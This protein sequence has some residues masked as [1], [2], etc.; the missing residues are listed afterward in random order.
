MRR[1]ILNAVSTFW[2]CSRPR[3][4]SRSTG[5][6]DSVPGPSLRQ[7]LCNTIHEVPGGVPGTRRSHRPSLFL[8]YSLDRLNCP[9]S[10]PSEPFARI[11]SPWRFVSLPTL[12]VV[13]Q[14]VSNNNTLMGSLMVAVRCDACLTRTMMIP[15]W[16]P[17]GTPSPLKR[18]Y[19]VYISPSS[20]Y[21]APSAKDVGCRLRVATGDTKGGWVRPH[22]SQLSHYPL[23][24]PPQMR[25]FLS[26]IPV[27]FLGLSVSA[28]A[29]NTTCKNPKVRREWRKLS[30]TE[31][32][33]WINAVNV[34]IPMPQ[35]AHNADRQLLVPCHA[36]P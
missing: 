11:P 15:P 26:I 18:E 24:S 4:V 3:A 7:G 27:L 28:A 6:Q 30:S 14:S 25:P 34:F 32:S 33:E 10:T 31:R 20:F 22:S 12:G 36:S 29:T 13:V 16:I 17:L 5:T 2:D 1:I 8:F 21:F 35:T 23:S 9:L 19:L